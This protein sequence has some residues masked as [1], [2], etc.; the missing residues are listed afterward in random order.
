[1]QY[2][3]L[4]IPINTAE[5]E[6]NRAGFAKA[7]E[8]ALWL[9]ETLNELHLN[10]FVKTSGKTGIHIYV[11]ITRR[12]NYKAVRSAAETAGKFL[13]QRHPRE[14]TT[15]WAQ[16]K[17]Q[18]KVFIDFGQ[19]VRGKTLACAYSPHPT[20]DAAISTPLL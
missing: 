9:K 5:P 7:C 18:G 20:P 17:R 6:L 8:V 2:A 13:L 10:A 11:P 16:E 3:H 19:N 15:K 4:N 1:M 12:L 14:I